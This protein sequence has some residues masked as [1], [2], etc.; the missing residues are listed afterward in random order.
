[1]IVPAVKREPWQ[2]KSRAKL[3]RSKHSLLNSNKTFFMR[4]VARVTTADPI[5]FPSAEIKNIYG[6]K[7][8]SCIDGG[9]G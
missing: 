2:G 3:F 1:V 9:I 4:D 8:F 6:T 7:S 5:L